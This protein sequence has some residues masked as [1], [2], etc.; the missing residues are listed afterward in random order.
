MVLALAVLDFPFDVDTEI[1]MRRDGSSLT[2][3]AKQ[4]VVVFSQE[5]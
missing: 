4:P 5:V 2:L 3:E 1:S